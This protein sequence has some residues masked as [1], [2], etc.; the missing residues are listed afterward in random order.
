[1]RFNNAK[2]RKW[3][4]FVYFFVVLLSIV[5]LLYMFFFKDDF[6][7]VRVWYA[8]PLSI[9][10]VIVIIYSYAKYF[11]F[12][13]D[14]NVLTFVNKGLFISNYIQYR[15]EHRAEFPKEKLKKY[16]IRNYI[17]FSFL[18]I[19]VRSKNNQIKRLYFNISLLS[20][21]KK[22][23]LKKSLDKVLK[24]NNQVS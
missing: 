14:G 20:G 15:K 3:I 17:L 5:A 6:K 19:Y 11:E 23:A 16:R 8:I 7:E 13:S 24:Q 10:L 22:R 2:S 18:Y 21:R 9:V 1:M 4:P 12:D